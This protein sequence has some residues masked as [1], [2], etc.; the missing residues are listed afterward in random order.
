MAHPQ[1]RQAIQYIRGK[2]VTPESQRQ[3]RSIFSEQTTVS[4]STPSRR[5]VFPSPIPILAPSPRPPPPF[6]RKFEEMKLEKGDIE[7]SFGQRTRSGK[8]HLKVVA[9]SPSRHNQ[10]TGKERAPI[11]RYLKF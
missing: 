8:Q 4:K 10:P 3:K 6:E 1:S 7:R 11:G 9:D 5:T 2:M